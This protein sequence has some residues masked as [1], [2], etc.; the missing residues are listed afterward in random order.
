MAKINVGDLRGKYGLILMGIKYD[1]KQDLINEMNSW[2]KEI[3]NA[4]IH[5]GEFVDFEE[6]YTLNGRTDILIN[7]QVPLIH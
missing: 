1:N 2:N 4:F 6:I 7:T 3:G 5:D